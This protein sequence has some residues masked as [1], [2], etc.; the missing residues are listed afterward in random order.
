MAK[1]AKKK[2]VAKAQGDR[3][4]QGPLVAALKKEG[5]LSL[6]VGTTEKRHPMY[7]EILK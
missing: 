6:I 7:K 5:K 1:L 4:P 3:N 2:E